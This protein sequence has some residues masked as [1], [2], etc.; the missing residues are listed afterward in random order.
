MIAVLRR[1]ADL[2]S[3]TLRR[4]QERARRLTPP[5]A[6]MA[7]YGSWARGEARSDSD[8]DIMIVLP[9]WLDDTA[10]DAYREQV[11]DWCAYAS[12]VAG[13]PV[14]PL[15]I[16]SHDS[17]SANSGTTS[18]ATPNSSP[19]AT[20]GRCWVPR[21]T[22]Q[23]VPVEPRDAIAHQKQAEEHLRAASIA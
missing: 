9:S 5:P 1:V 8:I 11:A 21:S 20:R 15:V 17:G 19:A 16:D 14:S 7:V 13:L 12:Q 23:R 2:R 10:K 22:G 3:E 18:A 4:W 6:S